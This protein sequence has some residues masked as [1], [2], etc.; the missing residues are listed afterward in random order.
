MSR[1]LG[2]R[3]WCAASVHLTLADIAVGCAL[4]WLDFRFPALDWRAR[5]ANLAQLLD[6]RLKPRASF[7]DTLPAELPA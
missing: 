2:E 6:E 3:T 7:E 4:G 5:Y 1:S